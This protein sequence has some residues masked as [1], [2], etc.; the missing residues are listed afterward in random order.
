MQASD[1]AIISR[2]RKFMQ[3]AMSDPSKSR[4]LQRWVLA[5]RIGVSAH[6]RI[7]VREMR[8][9][10]D[11]AKSIRRFTASACFQSVSRA[12]RL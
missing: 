5:E 10:F 1:E 4:R 7:G 3:N 8:L 6:R 2:S 11:I 9:L 12:R